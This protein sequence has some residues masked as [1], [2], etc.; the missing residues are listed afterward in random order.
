[1]AV[2]TD[3]DMLVRVQQENFSIDEEL[4]RVRAQSSR[5]GGIA[6]FLGTARDRSKGRDVSSMNFEHYEGMA[7]KKLKEIRQQA[8]QDF[9]II[10]A[11][12]LHRHGPIE[13]GENIVLI[14][15]G[16]EHRADA[17]K[18]CRWC[19]DELKKI[20]PIWKMEHTPEGEVWVEEHP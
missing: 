9:D 7:Q 2:E 3:N 19:I 12:V 4:E 20:T 14:I 13:I 6:M 16:A 10:E 18:A 1:M 17:F 15:V 11:L 5:I 8:L